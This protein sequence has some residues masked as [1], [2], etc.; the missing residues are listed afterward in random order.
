MG[1]VKPTAFA[2]GTGGAVCSYHQLGGI[3]VLGQGA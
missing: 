1:I 3:A 2:L